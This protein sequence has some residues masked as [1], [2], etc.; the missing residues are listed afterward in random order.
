MFAWLN[1][2]SESEVSSAETVLA[3]IPPDA[4]RDDLAAA[5][6]T[7]SAEDCTDVAN[8]LKVGLNLDRFSASANK[9]TGEVTV[10]WENF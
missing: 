7:P 3:E 8:L 2:D 1:P 5:L 10:Q 4:P 6:L 9:R